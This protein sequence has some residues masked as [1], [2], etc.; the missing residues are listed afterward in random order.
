M[1]DRRPVTI[2]CWCSMKSRV[3]PLKSQRGFT[4]IEIAIVVLVVTILLG[5]SVA[6]FPVQQELKQYRNVEKETDEIIEQ[7]IAFAQV[8]GRLPCPDTSAGA[9][10][11][12]GREDRIGINDC[13]AFFGFLP[14][15]TIG[16]N[17]RYNAAG[18]LVDP[19]GQEYRYAVSE[20][21]TGDGDIDLVTAGGIRNEGINNVTPDLHICDGSGEVGDDL[22]CGDVTG[23]PVVEDVAAVVISLGKDYEIPATSRT[24]AENVD[25]MH[26]GT[27][28][29]VYIFT[30][31]RDDYDDVVK[32]VSTNLLY[33]RMITANQLP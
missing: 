4:L 12:D 24:Q 26:D 13:E 5:Y 31:R 33:S 3:V 8:N 18:S 22:D 21:E 20:I 14:G 10:N 19:W 11:I 27:L 15:R 16:I 17:G 28:D 9:G 7:L 30:P 25:N 6:M 23:D 32:W 1:P 2:S 29:K